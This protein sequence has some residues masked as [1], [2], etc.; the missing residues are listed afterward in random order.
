MV[1]GIKLAIVTTHPIQYNAPV[2]QRL[3]KRGNI[4]IR[5]FYTWGEQVM[6][7]K[8]DPGFGKIVSW[9]IPLLE[10]YGFEFVLNKAKHPG[11]NHFFGIIN[12]NLIR[13]IENWEA[14]AVLVYGWNFEGHLKTL[15]YFKNKIP[16]IFRGDSTLL[17]EPQGWSLKKMIRRQILKWVYRKVDYALYVGIDNRAYFERHGLT[18]SQLIH[19]PHTIDVQRFMDQ[20]EQ[21]DKITRDWKSR[22]SIEDHELVFLFAG[23]L[24]E[25]KNVRLLIEAFCQQAFENAHLVIVGNGISEKSLK[26]EFE[27]NKRIHF[28]DFQNQSMMPSVYRLASV[29]VLP[30]LSETWGLSANEAMACG[31]II[32]MSDKCGGAKDLIISGKNG[33]VFKSNNSKDL[34]EKMN[35]VIENN[36]VSG[37][38]DFSKNYIL[39]FSIENVCVTVERL[40]LSFNNQSEQ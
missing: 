13:Q 5:V 26:I 19:A 1:K 17:M 4:S 18:S 7:S 27:G 36:S 10:G 29:F 16:V 3:S 33:Y 12:P 35:L 25:N 34:G 28:M 22:F 39:N 2:F 30:S 8:F 24:D 31:C 32:I 14:N 37:M 40:A 6:K 23:K 9:D 38:K 11:S 21:S 20:S 15:R